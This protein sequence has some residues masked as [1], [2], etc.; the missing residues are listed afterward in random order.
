MLIRL[1]TPTPTLHYKAS[2]SVLIATSKI[3]SAMLSPT[4]PFSKAQRFSNSPYYSMESFVLM[5]YDDDPVAL[6]IPPKALHNHPSVPRL[7]SF[8]QLVKMAVVVNKHDC[9]HAAKMYGDSWT[10]RW[11]PLAEKPGYKKWLFVAWMRA[12]R[13]LSEAGLP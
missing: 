12:W 9:S 11:T 4:S 6:C 7:L 10:K 13:N 1:L 2:A 8:K 5:L 3:F